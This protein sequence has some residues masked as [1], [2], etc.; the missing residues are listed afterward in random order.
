MGLRGAKEVEGIAQVLCQGRQADLD[1]RPWGSLSLP[2]ARKPTGPKKL[3]RASDQ[4]KSRS[5]EVVLG[6]DLRLAQASA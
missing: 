2:N 4:V 3:A 1:D 5:L 6:Y